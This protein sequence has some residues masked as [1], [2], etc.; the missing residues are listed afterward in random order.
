MTELEIE[1]FL[2]II[3]TGS[4]SAAA[5]E[6]YVTQPALSRR[7]NALE[8]E[9]GYTLFKRQ[10]GIRNIALTVEGKAFI[11]L[12]E[13]WKS[14][15]Q[16][17]KEIKKIKE[18]KNFTI[19]SVNS[20]GEYILPEIFKLFM[21]QNPECRL[22]YNQHHSLES[23]DYVAKGNY[24]LAIISDD[25][26]SNEVETIPLFRE[27]MLLVTKSTLADSDGKNICVTKLNPKY[28]I[29]L[30]WNPEYDV[31]H[32]HWFG[33]NSRPHV[34]L[35]QMSLM[36]YFLEQDNTWV[37][38]PANV[39]NELKKKK[40]MNVYNLL[41]GPDDMT[42]YYLQK[43]NSKSTY[44]EKFLNILKEELQK[45]VDIKVLL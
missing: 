31:W 13:K 45:N 4:I 36:E 8:K 29:R 17:T 2:T 28:E 37:I 41:N 27:K 44:R 22:I 32:N 24:E 5:D 25:M 11:S 15:L 33:S 38:T 39:A 35:D 1:A 30:P 26:Y 42:I 14:I 12:A 21:Q 18:N 10:K 3:K 40:Q 43:K 9:I 23:Y 20:I 16:E 19:A 6:L 7:I 34:F